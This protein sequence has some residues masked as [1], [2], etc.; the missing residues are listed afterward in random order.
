MPDYYRQ[1]G[2]YETATDAQVR[3]AVRRYWQRVARFRPVQEQQA[4][5]AAATVLSNPHLRAVY[6]PAYTPDAESLRQEASNIR[7]LSSKLRTDLHQEQTRSYRLEYEVRNL[8]TALTHALEYPQEMAEKRTMRRQLWSR[9]ALLLLLP[10]AWG[11]LI[12]GSDGGMASIAGPPYQPVAEGTNWLM[13]QHDSTGIYELAELM[14]Q[15]PGGAE[16]LHGFLRQ[17]VYEKTSMPNG[18]QLCATGQLCFVVDSTGQV[19]NPA[20]VLG[21]PATDTAG[22]QLLQ[23]AA[24]QLPRLVPG[25]VRARPVTV[26]LTVPLAK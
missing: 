2:I 3:R 13:T 1:L 15:Y 12:L 17:Q 22:R 6:D 16:G 20:Q 11:L 25:Y 23:L 19:Q 5:L 4:F 14:P 21:L 9:V 10:L 24:A 8:R 7:H 26:R 18:D